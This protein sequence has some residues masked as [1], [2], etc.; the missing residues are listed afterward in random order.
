MAPTMTSPTAAVPRWAQWEGTDVTTGRIEQALSE[1]RR[2]EERAAVRTSVLTLVI[3]VDDQAEAEAALSVVHELGARH[4]SRTIVLIVGPHQVRGPHAEAATVTRGRPS[5]RDAI[6]RVFSAEGEERAVFFEE[7]VVTIRGQGRHHLNSIVEPLSLPDVR[8]VAWLPSRLP[9][10]G[11]PLMGSAD[12]VVVD[13]R[14]VAEH[15]DSEIGGDVLARSAAISRRLPV[16]DLSWMR[17]TPWRSLL[18]GLF[19]GTDAR[20]FLSGITRIRIA[21][22]SGPRHLLGGWLM[23]RL[24]VPADRFELEPAEHVS[25]EVDA[26]LAGRRA[27]FAVRRLSGDRVIHAAAAIDEGP[28]WDQVLRMREQWAARALADALAQV[29]RDRGFEEA[30]SGARELQASRGTRAS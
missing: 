16:T 24:G 19:E 27:H 15:L 18:A 20:P 7:V 13:S 22:H 30:L 3:V 1:L 17:L 14:A 26:E 5:G 11:D 9:A 28:H 12:R 10:P 8:M 25:I 29:G 4:P 23:R 21:G 2:R 6:V